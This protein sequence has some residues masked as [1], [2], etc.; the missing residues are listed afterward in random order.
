MSTARRCWRSLLGVKWGD[1]WPCCGRPRRRAVLASSSNLT[2]ASLQRQAHEILLACS[3]CLTCRVAGVLGRVVA[4]GDADQRG[5]RPLP[6]GGLGRGQ[7]ETGSAGLRGRAGASDDPGPGGSDSH[8]GRDS[9]VCRFGFAVEVDGVGRPVAVQP[10]L[11]LPPPQPAGPAVAGDEE[12]RRRVPQVPAAG[13]SREPQLGRAVPPDDDR[14]RSERGREA[15]PGL[16]EGTSRQSRRPDQRHQRALLRSQRQ[17]CQ[18]P[19]PPAGRRLEAGSLLRH[20]V[21]FHSHL[22][23]QEEHSG[24]EVQRPDQVQDDRGQGEAVA[25]HVPD[26]CGGCRTEAEE[27]GRA[28]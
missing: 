11:C 3:V 2:A 8:R 5:D 1:R 10:R 6:G 27:D 17:L 23:D 4:V 28:A 19:R 20:G 12:E 7:G 21:V 9:S 16:P 24:R 18:V 25:V 22:P 14:S 26:R 15:R 13:G